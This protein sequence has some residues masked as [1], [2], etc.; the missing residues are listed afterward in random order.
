MFNLTFDES[1]KSRNIAYIDGGEYDK[2]ILY[3]N[4]DMEHKN[5]KT[6]AMNEIAILIENLYRTMNGSVSF[7]LLEQLRESLLKKKPP[8]NRELKQHY[9]RAMKMLDKGKN[10]EISLLDG[11]LVPMFDETVERMV[12]MIAGMSGS[13][14]ST[15]TSKLC[16]TY[17]LQYPTNKII[18]FS[19]K[20]EDPVFDRLEYIDRILIDEDLLID[21]LTL[22]ELEDSLVIFDDV[23]YSTNKDIDKELDRIRDLILQQGRSYRCSFVYISHQANNYKQTRTILNEC[24]SITVFPSMTTRYSLKYLL[25]RYF[26]FDKQQISKICSLPSRWVTIYKTPPLVLYSKGAY[27]V[28]C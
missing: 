22:N 17:R 13:G 1:E 24:N 4:S 12:F 3:I 7:K 11:E 20:P 15:Y 2:E 8:V 18:L 23:E 6:I 14:K 9:D 5:K 19:N 21:P 26:G 27:L 16:Q 10:K 25:E 28:D